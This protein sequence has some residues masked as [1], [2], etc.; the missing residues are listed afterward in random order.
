MGGLLEFGVTG[1]GLRDEL[2]RP[3]HKDLTGS[4]RDSCCSVSLYFK[5]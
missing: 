2:G 5:M 1:D 4:Y 3:V